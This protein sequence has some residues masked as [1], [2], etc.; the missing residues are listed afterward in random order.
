[1]PQS[2]C[3]GSNGSNGAQ[4]APPSTAQG[5]VTGLRGRTQDLGQVLKQTLQEAINCDLIT[6]GDAA[7]EHYKVAVQHLNAAQQAVTTVAMPLE[8]AER[9]VE[10]FKAAV[11][12]N[13]R[14]A[15]GAS[16]KP[17]E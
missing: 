6:A 7:T 8:I 16:S 15:V 2:A 11:Q 17:G 14:N 5:F 1:M 13:A 4:A 10:A 12:H 3:E 9:H